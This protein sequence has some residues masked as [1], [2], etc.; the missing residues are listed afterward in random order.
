MRNML[1]LNQCFS[2]WVL[3][4]TKRMGW[5][6]KSWGQSTVKNVWKTIPF[7]F[8]FFCSLLVF[9]SHSHGRDFEE[10]FSR[11]N[12]RF[13]KAKF[14]PTHLTKKIVVLTISIQIL[15]WSL[16]KDLKTTGQWA[17]QTSECAT[18]HTE[19]NI[20]LPG[21]PCPRTPETLVHA[22]IAGHRLRPV[23]MISFSP[24]VP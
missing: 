13:F 5:W 8:F 1:Y 12:S 19:G 14:S 15:W 20:Y 2:K 3:L 7:F 22:P 21:E 17:M 18:V 24:R 11:E 10:T 4:S 6:G 23:A 9:L 16:S